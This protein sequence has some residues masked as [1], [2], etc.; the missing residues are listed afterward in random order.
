MTEQEEA[1]RRHCEEVA[2]EAWAADWPCTCPVFASG[3]LCES[4]QRYLSDIIARERADARRQAHDLHQ[5]DIDMLVDA[6]KGSIA[7]VRRQ[8]NIAAG[9]WDVLLAKV[10]ALASPKP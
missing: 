5:G 10:R 9:A 8:G 6:V 1:E 3:C 4:P 7:M 2:A